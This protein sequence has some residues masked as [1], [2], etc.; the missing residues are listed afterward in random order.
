MAEGGAVELREVRQRELH[1]RQ[2]EPQ[3]GVRELGGEACAG[4]GERAGSA[5]PGKFA[6]DAWYRDA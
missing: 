6:T 1:R 3:G 4:A 5:M 2:G